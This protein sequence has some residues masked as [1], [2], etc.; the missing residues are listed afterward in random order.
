MLTYQKVGHSDTNNI[1]THVNAHSNQ[2]AKQA[3]SEAV[4]LFIFGRILLILLCQQMLCF[5]LY[6]PNDLDT[7]SLKIN[8]FVIFLS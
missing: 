5:L 2:K 6:A 7:N 4:I 3:F 8:T 1:L